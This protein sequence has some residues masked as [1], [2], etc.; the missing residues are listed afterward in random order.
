MV[1]IECDN[2]GGEETA[3]RY[4]RKLRIDNAQR[5]S[6]SDNAPV[7]VCCDPL[8]EPRQMPERDMS[9]TRHR[10]TRRPACG[11]LFGVLFDNDRENVR[12][13]HRWIQPRGDQPK[14]A[15]SSEFNSAERTRR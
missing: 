15:D 9:G 12:L 13:S 1:Q 6:P 4:R 10:V 7:L 14:F 3:R 8:I 2:R 5:I 11:E